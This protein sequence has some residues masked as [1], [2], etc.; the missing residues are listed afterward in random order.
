MS[1][2]S[3]SSPP[4][5]AGAG[6]LALITTAVF[7]YVIAVTMM[8][9]LLLDVAE[10]MGVTLAE[11]GLLVAAMGVPWALGAPFTGYLSD[12]VGRRPLMVL[13]LAGMGGGALV[14]SAAQDYWSLLLIRFASGVFGG[15]GPSSTMAAVGD[16]FPANRR[17]MAMGWFNLGFGLGA[18]AGVPIIAAIGGLYGWRAAFVVSGVFLLAMAALIQLRFPS[19]RVATVGAGPVETYRSVF[20]IVGLWPVLSANLLERSVF[21][22]GSTYIPSFL[23]LAYLLSPVEV[24][25][26]LAFVALGTVLGTAFGG[27]IGDRWARPFIFI[28]AQSITGL[29]GLALFGSSLGVWVSAGLGLAFTFAN[30]SS[31]P[32]MLAVGSELSRQHRGAVLGLLSFTNQAGVVLGSAAGGWVADGLGFGGLAATVL[33]SS[34]LAAAC[35]IPLARQR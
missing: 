7:G 27:M 21:Q 1:A 29:L 34:V 3:Q 20:R 22:L 33:L 23:I 26:P 13:A 5:Q 8:N 16:L 10:E 2:S 6:T 11:A 15:F 28:V 17:G 19:P 30:S 25:L 4:F 14:A 24:A 32:A 35:A 31:R 9:P 18:I 12:R